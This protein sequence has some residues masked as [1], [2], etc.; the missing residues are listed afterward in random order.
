[1]ENVSITARL[2][3]VSGK[4]H[5]LNQGLT[6]YDTPSGEKVNS[7]LLATYLVAA[8]IEYLKNK[9]ALEYR[10]DEI[11]AIMGKLPVVVLRRTITDGIGFE[12]LILEKLD[13][14][15][16]LIDLVKGII[17]ARYQMPEYQ[18]LWLI[19][20]E[21]PQAEFMRKE[22]VKTLFF[23]RWETRWIPEK[24]KPL[25]DE[26]LAELSPVWDATLNLP[27]IQTAVRDCNFAYSGTMASE[28]RHE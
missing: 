23:S 17:G 7:R 15:N 25:V 21:F 26:W 12:K 6:F 11:P 1:M 28:K 13:S 9:G 20:S 19:R 22:Q 10:L 5:G 18:V 27:W 3:M 4:L 8:T 16:N 2:F 14:E 24:V